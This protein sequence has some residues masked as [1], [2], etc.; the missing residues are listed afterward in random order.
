M[1]TKKIRYLIFLK[2]VFI[3]SLTCFGGPQAH[4]ALFIKRLVHQR[5][6]LS[7]EELMEML[8]LCQ[9]LPG[10][11]STQTI[12]AIGFKLGGPK[13]SYLTL[14]IWILP[15]TVFMGITALGISF[16][17]RGTL[18]R[19]TQ[20]IKPMGVAFIFFAAFVIGRKVITTKTSVWLMI[21][22]AVLGFLY[23]SPYLTPFVILFGGLVASSKYRKQ[24][25]M[26]KKPIRIQWS[27]FILWATVFAFVIFL[28]T[29]TKSLPIRLFENFYRNGSFAFGGGHILK[30][31]LYNE[32]VEFK[33]Y[34]SADEFLSGIA[35]AELVPGP[36]F[37]I[38][39]YVGSLSM[40]SW[41]LSGQVLGSLVAS[42]GIF[43]PGIFMIF[44]VIRFWEQLKQ[45]RGIRA[46]LEGIN[47]SSTGLTIAAGVSLSQPLVSDPINIITV[48][49]TLIVLYFEKVPSYLIILGGICLGAVY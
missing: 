45:Y 36:T 6:Y 35:I 39:S 20:F 8:A 10:P 33:H 28:G 47:A 40:R 3:L 18:I 7:E 30:P 16:F 23:P 4:L 32:F 12:T 11:T 13:L 46:S 21:L 24:E 15:A 2:D 14:L 48:L 25:K 1:E 27:N 34:L 5:R 22:A 37:S 41:G 17:E 29:I 42:F 26:E 9:L 43:L 49:I 31:L 44:F 38:A 19:L